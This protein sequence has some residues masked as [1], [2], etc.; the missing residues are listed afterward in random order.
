MTADH[1]YLVSIFDQVTQE[2]IWVLVHSKSDLN[3]LLSRSPEHHHSM[4]SENLGSTV[5]VK[6]YLRQFTNDE[7]LNYGN[8]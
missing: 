1:T 6:D 3:L 5:S 7:N 4:T 2:T 8:G